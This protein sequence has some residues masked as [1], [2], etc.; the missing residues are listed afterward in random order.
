ML[1]SNYTTTT[2]RVGGGSGWSWRELNV[3]GKTTTS[4]IIEEYTNTVASGT[5]SHAEGFITVASGIHSHAQGFNTVASGITKSIH[6]DGT[7]NLSTGD[8]SVKVT[9]TNGTGV[10]NVT[11]DALSSVLSTDTSSTCIPNSLHL[12]TV[13]I[14]FFKCSF[15]SSL[16]FE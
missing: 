9:S 7:L 4:F 11:G 10:T 2:T 8:M 6:N 16:G 12:S 14:K 1:D 3:S 13:F 15:N 5:Y